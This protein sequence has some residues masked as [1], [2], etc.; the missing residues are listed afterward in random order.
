MIIKYILSSERTPQ[1]S[2]KAIW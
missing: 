1:G 2:D